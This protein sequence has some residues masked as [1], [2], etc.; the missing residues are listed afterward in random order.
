MWSCVKFE[1]SDEAMFME[2]YLEWVASG[3]F[4]LEYAGELRIIN[5]L[6]REK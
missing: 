2:S 5:V 3:I 1:I 4:F 6:S